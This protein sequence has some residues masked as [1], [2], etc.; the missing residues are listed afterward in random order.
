MT[1]SSSSTRI[2][3]NVGP[4]GPEA[5]ARSREPCAV[6]DD[7]AIDQQQHDSDPRVVLGASLRRL[8]PA[9]AFATTLL[10]GMICGSTRP[11]FVAGQI[12]VDWHRWEE[13]RQAGRPGRCP[14]STDS[15]CAP[16]APGGLERARTAAEE[17][18]AGQPATAEG[19]SAE[20]ARPAKHH[21]GPCTD[22]EDHQ[23]AR[24]GAEEQA[25]VLSPSV[26]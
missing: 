10:I 5:A 12:V 1:R 15:R 20:T 16:A 17:V 21:Q 25:P 6:G 2:R 22:V 3:E 11:V 19:P 26:E 14:G 23:G 7:G 18:A 4:C 13:R 9:Q 24:Q 8:D